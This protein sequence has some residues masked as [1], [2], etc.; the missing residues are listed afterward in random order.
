MSVNMIAVVTLIYLA[1]C[2][3]LWFEGAR[4]MSLCFLGYSLANVGL[5]WALQTNLKP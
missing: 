1:T 3:S 5:I 2:V 4:G